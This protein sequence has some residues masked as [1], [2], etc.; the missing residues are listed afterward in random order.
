MDWLKV[1]LWNPCLPHSHQ[2]TWSDSGEQGRGAEGCSTNALPQV[3]LSWKSLGTVR[4]INTPWKDPSR[5]VPSISS[6]GYQDNLFFKL[7]IPY[8]SHGYFGGILHGWRRNW[9][10]RR[11]KI[12]PEGLCWNGDFIFQISEQRRHTWPSGVCLTSLCPLNPQP[13]AEHPF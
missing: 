6:S 3:L 1:T 2:E 5:L 13:W 7:N 11:V 10:S 12:V 9:N 4:V 8:Q